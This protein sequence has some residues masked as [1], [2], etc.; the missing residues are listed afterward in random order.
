MFDLLDHFA[1]APLTLGDHA[2][3]SVTVVIG[4][5]SMIVTVNA[6]PATVSWLLSGGIW[7]DLSVWNDAAPW[8]DG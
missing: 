7:N 4:D 2:T 3:G 5:G 6:A 1:G 8:E